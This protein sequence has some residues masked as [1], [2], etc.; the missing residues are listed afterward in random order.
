MKRV[1]LVV[2]GGDGDHANDNRST[3]E[4]WPWTRSCIPCTS[5]AIGFQRR[6]ER[7]EQEYL[8]QYMN[9]RTTAKYLQLIYE[10]SNTR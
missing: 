3:E 6:V 9:S 8:I 10:R 1:M 5:Q 7:R 4:T 2:R